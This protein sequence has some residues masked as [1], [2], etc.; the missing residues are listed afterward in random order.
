MIVELK[1]KI[2]YILYSITSMRFQQ[3]PQTLDGILAQKQKPSE[4]LT[5]NQATQQEF[6]AAGGNHLHKPV[7]RVNGNSPTNISNELWRFGG[8]F[9]YNTG[10]LHG[11]IK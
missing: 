9:A 11:Q 6:D 2:K 3:Q 4:F 10:I 5:S 1:L 8:H 7:P